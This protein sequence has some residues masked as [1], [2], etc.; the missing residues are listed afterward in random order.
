MTSFSTAGG[1]GLKSPTQMLTGRRGEQPGGNV[2]IA[3]L[4]LGA[5]EYVTLGGTLNT[6]IDITGSGVWTC[7]YFMTANTSSIARVLV[8]IDGV[9]VLDE[10]TTDSIRQYGM[11]QVN[12]M[13][14]GG[15]YGAAA[16]PVT[17]PFNKSLKVE[18]QCDST[19]SYLYNYY[20]T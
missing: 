14:V 12:S 16:A 20:L 11:A 7:G 18:C 5:L 8:T 13:F 9:Q 15:S 2:T 19:A 17:I 1:G 10:S 6:A 4:V 3:K